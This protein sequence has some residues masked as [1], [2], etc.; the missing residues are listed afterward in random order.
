M[1]RYEN[2]HR[3]IEL[4]RVDSAG[5]E[6]CVDPTPGASALQDPLHLIQQLGPDAQLTLA[7]E[8]TTAFDEGLD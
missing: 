3:D 7:T 1:D 4:S 2:H 8:A 6:Q 5:A